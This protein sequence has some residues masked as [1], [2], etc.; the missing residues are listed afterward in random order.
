MKVRRD[1]SA[2]RPFYMGIIHRNYIEPTYFPVDRCLACGIIYLTDSLVC[3]LRE[4]H[5][6]AKCRYIICDVQSRYIFS[7]WNRM[8]EYGG[9][10][11]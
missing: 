11:L 4:N 8:D 2:N 1:G 7:N 3:N 5:D 10:V 6:R 9:T